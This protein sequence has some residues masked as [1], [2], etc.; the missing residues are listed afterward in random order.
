MWSHYGTPPPILLLSLPTRGWSREFCLISS[1]HTI[2]FLRV[3]FLGKPA[4]TLPQMS[5]PSRIFEIEKVF[6]TFVLSCLPSAA[7]PQ[8]MLLLVTAPFVADSFPGTT[9]LLWPSR[10]PS[11]GLYMWQA[12]F[13]SLAYVFIPYKSPM[14]GY[15]DM[16][17]LLK[18]CR[19]LK[20]ITTKY[21]C[22][23]ANRVE[24]NVKPI[25]GSSSWTYLRFF[26][27]YL[28]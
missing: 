7:S 4:A 2:V 23:N 24:Q 11:R 27:C 14:P 22:H 12:P 17:E 19:Q 3:C 20:A 13:P 15:K 8:H 21:D 18:H 25:I 1:L 26:L 28:F 6:L 9:M 16:P 5:S 10:C